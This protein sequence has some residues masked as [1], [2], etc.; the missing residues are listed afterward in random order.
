MTA[1]VQDCPPL[2]ART[3]ASILY[4]HLLLVT[5]KVIY[6]LP[7]LLR[8]CMAL[9]HNCT[10]PCR[11]RLLLMMPIALPLLMLMHMVKV[12][13][14]FYIMPKL[15]LQLLLLLQLAPALPRRPSRCS[16]ALPPVSA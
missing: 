2:A 6:V 3:L 12:F 15:P 11:T 10:P 16:G 7:R 5:L 4:H 9:L 13:L 1:L 8:S 14:S